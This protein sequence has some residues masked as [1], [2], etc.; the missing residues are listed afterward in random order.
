MGVW[1]ETLEL[2]AEAL[3]ARK[4]RRVFPSIDHGRIDFFC[5]EWS[6]ADY[7]EAMQ[8]APA[9]ARA[10]SKARSAERGR[11]WGVSE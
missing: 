3:R 8:A 7:R 11:K 1:T 10:R 6:S 4:S 2:L 5:K 9:F